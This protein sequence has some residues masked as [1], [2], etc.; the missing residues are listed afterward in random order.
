MSQRTLIIAKMDPG[1]GPAVADIFAESDAS[2]L[3]KLIGVSRRTLFTFHGLYLHLVESEEPVLVPLAI[4][5][6]HPL[7]LDVNRKLA[8]YMTPYDPGWREPKDS[9]ARPF[10]EWTP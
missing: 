6:D 3:P 9:M 4:Y 1:D 10:Y 8:P 2:E 7:F 5:R